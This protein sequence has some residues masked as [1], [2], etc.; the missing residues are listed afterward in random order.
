MA[1]SKH[2]ST[3]SPFPHAFVLILYMHMYA[4]NTQYYTS[5]LSCNLT[6]CNRPVYLGGEKPSQANT[7]L[8]SNKC[9]SGK[10]QRH[11]F[12]KE[13]THFCPHTVPVIYLGNITLHLKP[14]LFWRSW[15]RTRKHCKTA[16]NDDNTATPLAITRGQIKPFIFVYVQFPSAKG[17]PVKGSDTV[18]LVR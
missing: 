15:Y 17:N 16:H 1:W 11:Q 2:L 12:W 5:I 9:W 7:I 13:V 10:T 18:D 4:H 8:C 6:I 14:E 3:S